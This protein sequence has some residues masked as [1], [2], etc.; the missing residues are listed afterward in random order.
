MQHITSSS[1]VQLSYD[2]Y[3]SGPPLVLVHGSFCTHVTNWSLIKPLLRPRFEVYAVARR[4]RGET[5]ATH[6]H[7]VEDEGQ[8]IASLLDSFDQP[9]HL[10]GHSYGAQIALAAAVSVPHRVRKLILYEPPRTDINSRPTLARLEELASEN[11]WEGFTTT[12]LRETIAM[13]EDELQQFRASEFWPSILE[14]A[15]RTLQEVRALIRHDFQPDR[16]RELK[17]PVLLQIGTE[18]RRDLY[19]TDALASVLPDVRIQELPGQAHDAMFTA[20]QAYADA[21]IDFLS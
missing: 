3:G 8:D 13:S 17:M 12:F 2:K 4:G 14:E 6:D 20:P 10:L 1:G 7:T 18:S 19:V 21:V 11:D 15:P 5:D 16:C 9:V